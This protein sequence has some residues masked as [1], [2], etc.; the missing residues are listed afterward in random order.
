MIVQV[1]PGGQNGGK[2][3]PPPAMKDVE[4]D[5]TIIMAREMRTNVFFIGVAP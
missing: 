3:S 4:A 5:A 2:G 1:D